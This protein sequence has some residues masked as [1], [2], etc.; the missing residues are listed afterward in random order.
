[1][2]ITLKFNV[3][4]SV[5]QLS[6]I[7]LPPLFLDVNQCAALHCVKELNHISIPHTYATVRCG[8]TDEVRCWCTVYIDI[9]FKRIDTYALI[10]PFF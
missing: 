4:H 2:S 5:R 1:M 10:N 9:A 7:A 8:L 3:I 6:A